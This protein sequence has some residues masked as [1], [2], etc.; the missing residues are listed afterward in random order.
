MKI[1]NL[2]KVRALK[3]FIESSELVI[4]NGATKKERTASVTVSKLNAGMQSFYRNMI[5]FRIISGAI[6]N[7]I[8][9]ERIRCWIGVQIK[10]E[11]KIMNFG[12]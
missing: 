1:P 7:H 8:H 2:L 5:R 6:V 3:A 9:I 4:A 12:Q 10:Q 11:K